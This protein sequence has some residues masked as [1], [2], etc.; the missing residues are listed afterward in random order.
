MGN[1]T[2][3]KYWLDNNDV[4]GRARLSGTARF[5]KKRWVALNDIDADGVDVFIEPTVRR[6]RH[7]EIEKIELKD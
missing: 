3:N 1:Y 5:Y 2:V 6:L 7:D 4:L